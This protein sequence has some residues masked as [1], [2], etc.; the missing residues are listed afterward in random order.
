MPGLTYKDAGVDQEAAGRLAAR[1]AELARGTFG[2]QILAD[3]PGGPGGAPAATAFSIDR[4]PGLL[5]RRVR[6]PVLVGAANGVGTKL[7]LAHATGRHEAVGIDLVALSANDVIAL[8]ARPLFF[9]HYLA[10]GRIDP[11]EGEAVLRGVAE[12]CRLAGCALL[13]GETAEMRELHAPG[14][15]DLAGFC[16][17][18]A[19]RRKLI[20]GRAVEAGDAILG[21]ASSGLHANGYTL[22]RRALLEEAK[23]RLE[24]HIEELGRTLAEE[25]L[26]PAR[27]YRGAV[28]AVL[29]HYPV[30]GIVHAL[31]HVKAGGLVAALAR[32]AGKGLA[33]RVRRKALHTPPIFHVIE[34]AGKVEPEEMFRVFNM[35]VGMLLV[36]PKYNAAAICKRLA[37]HGCPARRIGEIVRD[38]GKGKVEIK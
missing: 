28:E 2:P 24:A 13:G 8:G 27:V 5:A 14:T 38:R 18:I 33:A 34:R 35:G 25:L 20:D 12:G 17:G 11:S 32:V 3:A 29:A 15:Y 1:A 10:T 36:C 6:R 31:A 19:D 21:L 37:R 7:R 30:K 9:L 26:D 23:L 16:V 22:A 4:D